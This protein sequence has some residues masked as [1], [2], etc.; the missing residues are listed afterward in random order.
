MRNAA[1]SSKK[2]SGEEVKKET[3][4]KGPLKLNDVTVKGV[5]KRDSNE[6]STLDRI[7]S[8]FIGEDLI[9]DI[10]HSGVDVDKMSR[11]VEQNAKVTYDYWVMVFLASTIAA[12][13]LGTNSVVTVIASMLVSPIAGPIVSCAFGVQVQDWA[14]VKKNSKAEL[15]SVGLCILFGFIYSFWVILLDD[16]GKLSSPLPTGE[17]RGR[18]EFDGLVP[19]TVVAFASGVAAGLGSTSNNVAGLIGVAISGSLLPPLVNA[20]MYFGLHVSGYETSGTL[21]ADVCGKG[22]RAHAL[23]PGAHGGR[24]LDN[25]TMDYLLYVV[26]EADLV[27]A[28]DT[29]RLVIMQRLQDEFRSEYNECVYDT[30][31]FLERGLVT[32]L[33][34]LE[35]IVLIGLGVFL[36]FARKVARERRKQREIAEEAVAEAAD[37]EEEHHRLGEMARHKWRNLIDYLP[38]K[39]KENNAITVPSAVLPLGGESSDDGKSIMATLLVRVTNLEREISKLRLSSDGTASSLRHRQ[40]TNT[41]AEDGSTIL[42]VQVQ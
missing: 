30:T 22:L 5:K 37:E 29:E 15:F 34:A 31:D 42:R 6:L 8:Y 28:N 19:A 38:R 23:S 27:A 9:R 13:G 12:F 21:L 4:Q 36:V 35:N 7:G 26:H 20:G 24:T 17:M 18:A 39:R 14:R 10:A 41:E 32:F 11:V 16:R 1:L 25:S 40:N 2:E 3:L 33:L